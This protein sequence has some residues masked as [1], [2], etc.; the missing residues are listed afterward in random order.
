MVDTCAAAK[1]HAINL[2]D[3]DETSDREGE[4]QRVSLVEIYLEPMS[5]LLLMLPHRF[6]SLLYTRR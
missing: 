2:A 5:L 4:A 3:D 1:V 6:I